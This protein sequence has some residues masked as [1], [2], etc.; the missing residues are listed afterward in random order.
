MEKLP[1]KLIVFEGP[2]GVGKTTVSQKIHAFMVEQGLRSEWLSFPGREDGSLGQLV[3]K[4]HH[5][6]EQYGVRTMTS[7]AKQ[8]LHIAAHIDAIEQRIIPWLAQGTHVVMDRYW[9]STWVYGVTAGLNQALLKALI[10][11]ERISWGGIRPA[12]VFL[13][14]TA[15]PRERGDENIT[16]WHALKQSYKELAQQEQSEQ[17]VLMLSNDATLEDTMQQARKSLSS[18]LP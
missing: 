7:A 17:L 8:A 10:D 14:E 6:P 3:Y 13:V 2:D 9:W 1:G 16:T 18:L 15:V 11:A 12:A 4:L 5:Q